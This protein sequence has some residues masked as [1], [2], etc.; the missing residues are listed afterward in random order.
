MS[1]VSFSQR[2]AKCKMPIKKIH[3]KN[4]QGHRDTV[5]K[6]DAGVNVIK[7]T[8]HSGKST[9]IRGLQWAFFNPKGVDLRAWG[10]KPSIPVEVEITKTDG[11]EVC[12]T[13][14][15]TKNAYSLNG[16]EFKAIGFGVPGEIEE[17]LN[18][19]RINFQHQ[20]EAFY[21]FVKSSSEVAKTL[22]E[23]AKISE[24]D[25]CFKS[26][27][28]IIQTA[29]IEKRLYEGNVEKTTEKISKL[30]WVDKAKDSVEEL[31]LSLKRKAEIN[32]KLA[33]LPSHIRAIDTVSHY[34]EA[35]EDYLKARPLVLKLKN[36]VEL[37][38]K[39]RATIINLQKIV[40]S[41]VR[42]KDLLQ[43]ST[44]LLEARAELAS[45]QDMLKNRELERRRIDALKQITNR[46]SEQIKKVRHLQLKIQDVSKQ[47]AALLKKHKNEFCPKCGAYRSDWRKK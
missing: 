27:R 23:I 43:K 20:K 36:F 40:R 22:N 38:S 21:L 35:A 33:R 26:I 14:K 46:T 8:S 34:I 15:G 24:V 41:I 19:N 39:H 37:Q 17:A 1:E 28:S 13:K 29:T 25:K 31:K 45:I 6:L 7:G 3:L 11:R 12:R 2:K 30:S 18:I 44:I 9:I 16:T 42:Q 4:V 32:K 10:V 47:R 5:L